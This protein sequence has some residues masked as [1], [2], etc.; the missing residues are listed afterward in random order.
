MEPDWNLESVSHVSA[1]SSHSHLIL[2]DV[3]A[4]GDIFARVLGFANLPREGLVR[5]AHCVVIGELL[6]VKNEWVSVSREV[7][8]N[9]LLAGDHN[10]TESG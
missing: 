9:D 8:A 7:L 10:I 6:A 5:L 1:R 3:D 2:V 4:R